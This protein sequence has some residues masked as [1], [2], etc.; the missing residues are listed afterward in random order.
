ML[1]I[2]SAAFADDVQR[3]PINQ[4][5]AVIYHENGTDIILRSDLGYDLAGKFR[6]LK[7]VILEHL[8]VLDAAAH[9]MTVSDEEVDR[10]LEAIKKEHKFT[11]AALEKIFKDAGFTYDEGR[12]YF[13]NQRMIN[14][15][16]EYRVRSDKRMI[17]EKQDVEKYYAA[18][19]QVKEA[20]VTLSIAFIPDDVAT[21][22]QVDTCVASNKF[23]TGVTWDEPITIPVTEL[24]EDRA[25]VAQ[26]AVGDIV[27]VE[28]VEGG[29]EITKLVSKT[30][31]ETISFD[32]A[33]NSIATILRE[34]RGRGVLKEYQ[35]TLLADA[36]IR[37]CDESVSLQD[38]I[39]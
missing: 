18:H 11:Q 16:L 38:V 20:T 9:N 24:A 19:P 17:I 35:D 3:Y 22:E 6:N 13:K 31:Q 32:E 10:E 1:G 5:L 39:K 4:M 36:R 2:M 26:K 8:M 28:A 34:E 33:Y 12:A 7:D 27:A 29:H 23:P 37:L 25:F 30:E 15:I 14:T 21:R